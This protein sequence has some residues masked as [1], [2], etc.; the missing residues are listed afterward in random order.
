MIIN[1]PH[2]D[3][4]FTKIFPNYKFHQTRNFWKTFYFFCFSTDLYPKISQD[5]HTAENTWERR[6]GSHNFYPIRHSSRGGSFVAAQSRQRC[7]RVCVVHPVFLLSLQ[8]REAQGIES[9]SKLHATFS[10][11]KSRRL[12][13]PPLHPYDALTVEHQRGASCL[14][15]KPHPVMTGWQCWQGSAGPTTPPDL[16]AQ[17]S[18]SQHRESSQCTE[19]APGCQ[20]TPHC[21]CPPASS[22]PPAMLHTQIW[23]SLHVQEWIPLPGWRFSVWLHR[24][25][26]S[27]SDDWTRSL[28]AESLLRAKTSALASSRWI[29]SRSVVWDLSSV[30]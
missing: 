2:R 12:A 24:G 7:Q 6:Q 3:K 5:V 27:R 15:S 22:P 19:W 30:V 21:P 26:A 10:H 1:V 8:Q 25:S 29:C 14:G 18:S 17:S 28:G 20:M 9:D 4:K 11:R 23:R 16:W 13:S